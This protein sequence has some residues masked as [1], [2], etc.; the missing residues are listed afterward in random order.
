[1]GVGQVESGE[2]KAFE[3]AVRVTGLREVLDLGFKPDAQ[4]MLFLLMSADEYAD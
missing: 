2:G 1:M 4:S 3:A